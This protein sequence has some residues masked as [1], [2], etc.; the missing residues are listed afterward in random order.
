[1]R[2][3]DKVA[4][5]TGGAT[6][7]R[8]VLLTATTAILG[9]VPMAIG[10]DFDFFAWKWNIDS[11]SSEMW[12]PLSTCVIFGLSFA[13]LLTLFVVP[14]L[15]S[16]LYQREDRKSREQA[17]AKQSAEETPPLTLTPEQLDAPI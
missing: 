3:K 1:M 12:G 10:V 4:V 5:I 2:L 7:F 15:Y 9:L 17:A 16:L 14:C 6:R 13:T 8:P 11:S